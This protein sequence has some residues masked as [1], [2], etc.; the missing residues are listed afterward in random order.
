M[1][2]N[3]AKRSLTTLITI[4]TFV[5]GV[6]LIISVFAGIPYILE[7]LGNF[8]NITSAL[9]FFILGI[10]FFIILILLLEIASSSKESIFISENVKRFRFIGYMLFVNGINEYI[11]M[12]VNGVSGIRIFDLAPGIFIT[13]GMAVYFIVA[14][15]C[16]VISDSFDE[17]IRIKEDNNL[18]I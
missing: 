9:S 17:A 5:L 8:K 14:L 13:L 18:T 11:T 12:L 1:K 2:N 3:L 4:I 6:A 16:F 7:N 15:I 10:T